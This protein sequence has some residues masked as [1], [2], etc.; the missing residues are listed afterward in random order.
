MYDNP[1]RRGVPIFCLMV[2]V[3][4]SVYVLTHNRVCL[5]PPFPACAVLVCSLFSCGSCFQLKSKPLSKTSFE[6]DAWRNCVTSKR[7]GNQVCG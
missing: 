3:T 2:V 4:T 6:P 1:R 5:A 7:E